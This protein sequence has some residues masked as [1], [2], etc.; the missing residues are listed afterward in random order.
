MTYMTFKKN[1]RHF[2]ILR[3][4]KAML[5]A[6]RHRTAKAKAKDAMA[7]EKQVRVIFRKA[8]AVKASHRKAM[9]TEAK[10]NKLLRA[11]CD[12]CLQ[13]AVKMRRRLLF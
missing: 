5:K 1:H 3:Q 6:V 10:E 12:V 13:S 9:Y 11:P 7:M 4:V 8:K 2:I